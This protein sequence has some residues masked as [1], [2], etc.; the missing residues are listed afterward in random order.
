MRSVNWLPIGLLA[1]LPATAFLPACDGDGN[2]T[3]G[4]GGGT[5][6]NGGGGTTN[7]TGGVG[8]TTGGTGGTG[9]NMGGTGGSTGGTG[10]VGGFEPPANDLCDGEVV[11]VEVGSSKIVSGTLNGAT[12]NYTTFCADTTP[13]QDKVDV[14][15]QLEIPSEVTATLNVT[16]NGFNPAFSLRKSDCSNRMGGDNCLVGVGGLV[17]GKYALP[18]GK[19]WIV[20]DSADGKT[21]KFD[22]SVQYDAPKCGDGVINSNEKCDPGAPANDDGCFNPGT[23]NECQ[24]GEPPPDPA[25]V[26]CPGGLI[27]VG[28]N[29][30]LQLGPFNNGPGGTT[31]VNAFL[32]PNECASPAEGPENVFHIVPKADGMLTVQIGYAEDGVSL[33]CDV[34][35]DC[36]DFIMYLRKGS[37]TSMA[38]GDQLAC[39][40]Y[41]DN[42]NSPFGYDEVLTVTSAVTADTDYWLFVDGLDLDYGVGGYFLQVNLQ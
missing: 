40:D 26:S 34:N 18:A 6:S 22:L 17:G 2:N 42:P 12:D 13:D 23:P 3:G 5:T 36:G 4:T 9:G 15:Y 35:P 25:I 1:L 24:F 21:G 38:A 39:D 27:T 41:T 29:D 31:Q 10:G 32:D 19:A 30:P 11:T 7:P 20:V 33:Y 28:K 37:C 14:V 16:A 8:G